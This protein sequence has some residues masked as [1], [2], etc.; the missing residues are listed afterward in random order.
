MG[1]FHTEIDI[2]LTLIGIAFF[3]QVRDKADD[4]C[5]KLYYTRMTS[6]RLNTKSRHVFTEGSDV[7][8]RDFLRC[9]TF[10]L[11]TVDNLI[12]HI[13]KVRNIGNLIATIL[14]IATNGIEG[15]CR[16]GIPYVNVVV[17]S[18]PTDIHLDLAVLNW[19]KF[20]QI[21]RHG[22]IDFNHSLTPFCVLFIVKSRFNPTL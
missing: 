20:S 15:Y 12:I 10:F 2:P 22:V 8:I 21:T 16:T 4:I 14:K 3:N 7:L 9:D 1:F 19:D 13:R 5:H 17:Y 18:W 11:G 6:R